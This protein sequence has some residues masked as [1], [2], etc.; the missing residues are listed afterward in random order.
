MTEKIVVNGVKYT[1]D[2][3]PDQ[4]QHIETIAP[5]NDPLSTFKNF[6]FSPSKKDRNFE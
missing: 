5:P 3:G 2:I 6:T 1:R 4:E